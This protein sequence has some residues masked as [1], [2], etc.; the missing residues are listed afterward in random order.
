M[1][2]HLTA[3]DLV[4]LKDPSNIKVS[5]S[6][7]QVV[8]TL[9]QSTREGD[10]SVSSI[11]VAEIGKKHSSRQFTSGQFNDEKPLW[12]P[13]GE[14]IAFVSDREKRGESSA[15]YLISTQGGEAYPVTKVE[16]KKKISFFRWSFDGKS[17]AFLS[18]DEKT[19][20]KEKKEKDKDD[21]KV[22]GDW[23]FARLRLLDISTKEVTTLVQ[24]DAHVSEFVW[25]EDS[26]GIVY[27]LHET[28]ELDSPEA[29]GVKFEHFDL[30]SKEST[31]IGEFPGSTSALV[32]TEGHAFFLAGAEPKS[33][34]TSEMLYKMN[35][36]DGK[37]SKVAYGVDSCAR[38]LRWTGNSIAV[39]VMSGLQDQVH[40]L[41]GSKQTIFYDDL[42]SISGKWD[43]SCTGGSIVLAMGRSTVNGPTEVYSIENGKTCLLSQHS[44]DSAPA[45]ALFNARETPI[46]S[47]ARDGT[48]LDAIFWTPS[49]SKKAW[50]TVVVPHGGPYNRVNMSFDGVGVSIRYTPW[51]LSLGYAVLAPN[52]RGG[53]G[54]GEDFAKAAQGGM[55]T[56][57]YSDVID[58]LKRCISQGLVDEKNVATCGWSQGGF[59][60]YLAV[61]RKEFQYRAAI[62]GA[63]VTDWDMLCM[64]SDAPT[65]ESDLAGIA[66]WIASKASPLRDPVRNLKGAVTPVLI[67]HGEKD[68]R[69][70]ISQATAFKRG[71]DHHGVPCEMVTYPRE[72]H[73]FKERNHAI[74]RL[75]RI[76]SF[77]EK[78]M[79]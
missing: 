8:Y 30:S 36:N 26:R 70:P 74:D 68:E 62:C 47:T 19:E 72:G 55:G 25:K 11:W 15:I 54:H 71:C 27:I 31:K 59:L 12:S 57:D 51:L 77:L 78:H 13:N 9:S 32:L 33:C 79:D 17:I 20:E 37:W 3:E 65:F 14:L 10:H 40:L 22:Y 48:A 75:K 4:D 69:V 53:A 64:T 44:I 39:H 7:K 60:S 2:T 16:N 29:K 28:P 41:D 5:P 42:H 63:G 35:L 67:L 23:E 1:S 61:T 52:Y 50:P 18:A 58:V 46:Y 76:K 6:G 45:S 34:S 66:P 21:A 43:V 24:K 73:S 56:T 38:A 49:D